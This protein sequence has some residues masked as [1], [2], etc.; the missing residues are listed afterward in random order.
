MR[1]T[2]LLLLIILSLLIAGCSEEMRDSGN[3]AE[4]VRTEFF[5]IRRCGVSFGSI[6]DGITDDMFDKKDESFLKFCTYLEH[7][8]KR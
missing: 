1:R 2:T 3:G 6:I 7:S 5:A 8:P 4:P